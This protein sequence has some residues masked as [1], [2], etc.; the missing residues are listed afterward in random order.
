MKN[1]MIMGFY[2]V[3]GASSESFNDFEKLLKLIGTLI[4]TLQQATT[5]TKLGPQKFMA[6][7]QSKLIQ[8]KS[9]LT[10]ITNDILKLSL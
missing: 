8:A 3:R 5:M 2:P 6:D 4:D 1:P 10:D 9:D 7:T